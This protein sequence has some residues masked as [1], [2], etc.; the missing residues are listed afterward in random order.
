MSDPITEDQATALSDVLH[1]RRWMR[2]L[3]DWLEGSPMSWQVFFIL[4]ECLEPDPAV[5]LS[6]SSLTA[7]SE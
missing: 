2:D 4:R 3:V 5:S 6:G 1:E 7:I